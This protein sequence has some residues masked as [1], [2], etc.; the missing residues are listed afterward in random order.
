M[1][2]AAANRGEPPPRKCFPVK[3]FGLTCVVG[4]FI[5]A[6]GGVS[7][8]SVFPI[9][10]SVEKDSA[11]YETIDAAIQKAIDEEDEEYDFYGIRI[12]DK[13][14]EGIAYSVDSGKQTDSIFNSYDLS[15]FSIEAEGNSGVGI[16]FAG[17]KP[18]ESPNCD[19]SINAGTV[20]RDLSELGARWEFVARKG[21]DRTT[22]NLTGDFDFGKGFLDFSGV[23]ATLIGQG[24]I[25]TLTLWEPP[26][27][28]SEG[29]STKVVIQDDPSFPRRSFLN[30]GRLDVTSGTFE[31]NG[32]HA[33]TIVSAGSLEP[34]GISETEGY[35]GLNTRGTGGT[36]HVTGKAALSLIPAESQEDL[37]S[38]QTK[39]VGLVND[40]AV[41]CGSV[42]PSIV[43]ESLDSV[44]F[45]EGQGQSLLIRV[46]ENF[47]GT[48]ASSGIAVGQDGR[49]IWKYSKPETSEETPTNVRR[50]RRAP[51]QTPEPTITVSEGSELVIHGW[52]G[53]PSDI[54][55][56]G[57]SRVIANGNVHLIGTTVGRGKVVPTQN[58]LRIERHLMQ[59]AV[60]LKA[61]HCVQETEERWYSGAFSAPGEEFIRTAIRDTQVGENAFVQLV[62]TA[63]FLPFSSRTLVYAERAFDSTHDRLLQRPILR[64]AQENH[65]WVTLESEKLRLS[66]ATNRSTLTTV[67]LGVDTD[68]T[69]T[70]SASAVFSGTK[71]DADDTRGDAI[72]TDGSVASLGVSLEKHLN[73]KS[74][75]RLGAT[76]A[77]AQLTAKQL[78]AGH[79]FKTEPELLLAALGARVDTTFGD[80]VLLKPFVGAN[81]YYG[82][83]SDGDIRHHDQNAGHDGIGFKTEAKKRMWGSVS[84]GAQVSGRWDIADYSIQPS[85]GLIGKAYLGERKWKAHA[86]LAT[87]QRN[88]D[89]ADFTSTSSW[90]VRAE[91]AI[92]LASSREV[93]VTEG[94]IFGFGAK[95]TGKVTTEDWHV[96]LTAGIARS[97]RS[98]KTGY[99]RVEYRQNW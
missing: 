35:A 44:S 73:E 67:R 19:V 11:T 86:A 75:L 92:N 49:I 47:E 90:S 61:F 68:L 72:N 45:P 23:N 30:I 65:W 41:T 20:V 83:M 32:R 25:G 10:L 21:A 95:P 66:D 50:M 36:I 93:P 64:T 76:V 34:E 60:G 48:V 53:S 28:A 31:I 29:T 46:G 63:V 54:T 18:K 39:I 1:N 87:G 89:Y 98:E 78:A 13:R 55:L 77:K 7:A 97:E 91:A 85:F 43:L 57:F 4:A 6:S 62:D 22:V 79:R 82:K 94:G 17:E 74:A 5:S 42:R 88:S 38:L 80:S 15:D 8:E 58:G 3:M 69:D 52:D 96:D 40:A 51:A 27:G 59:N 12:L 14:K 9:E 71:F 99:V 56:P 24:T 2:D 81:L 70:W 16:L 33:G 84:T 26:S 37:N